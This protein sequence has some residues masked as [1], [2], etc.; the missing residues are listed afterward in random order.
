[1][2]NQ[3]DEYNSQLFEQCPVG[4][5]LCRTDG[6]LININLA[7]AAILGRTIPE[8]LNLN[9]WQITPEN[10]AIA[11]Q[12]T[13][14]NL[15]QTGRYGPYE[16][17][18]IHKDGHL[19]PVRI[20]GLMIEKDGQQLIWSSVEDIS[21]L[22]CI[23]QE[24]QHNE[25]ILK[26]SEAR[27]RSLVTANT[28]IVW[29]STP[30]G[31]CFELASWIAYTGQSLAEAENGGWIDAVHPDD[32]AYTGQ[33]WSAAVANLSMYQIEYR[34]RGKDGNYRYFWV[35]GAPVI[36]EDGSVREWIGTCTDIQDRKLAEAENQRLQERY[37]SLVTA[38]SQ[39]VWGATPEGLGISSEM[40]TWMDYT[41]QSEAE[42]EGWGWIDPIHPD[43]R[44]NSTEVW[45]AA[46]ANRGIYQ[47]E[48]RLC[49]KDGT[50]RYFSVC[51]A[52]VLE[53]DGSIREWI[54]TCTD[55]HDRK[56]AEAENQR[57][58]DMLNH[59]SDAIIVRDMSDK[60][61]HWNHGAERLYGWTREEVKDKCIQ[62]FI[63]KPFLNQKRNYSRVIRARELGRRS[64]TSHP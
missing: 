5:V 29:V 26:Q 2:F 30:Q 41:G 56:L 11:D 23:Q 28:Q 14:E 31:I 42:V 3:L 38:T 52:P 20:S 51:G 54:V 13:L 24:R 6:T 22:R 49:G 12:A 18:L 47:T 35:W 36:E 40:L 32:R 63:K 59:S 50:Y 48:Y 9:Y 8:T 19:V 62:A 45:N 58:L 15:K 60:I 34:I 46:V 53:E 43:D 16:K 25:Q 33:V 37:R 1:M 7:Y 64:G 57:L 4:L 55:I 44:A 21:D 17:E 61:S 39:I 10:Y 27:Y